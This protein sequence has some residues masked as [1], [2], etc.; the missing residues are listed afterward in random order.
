[1]ISEKTTVENQLKLI[2]E[3]NEKIINEMKR[4]LILQEQ[5]IIEL[6]KDNQILHNEIN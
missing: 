6:E 2:R 3:E 1:M 5:K 4:K